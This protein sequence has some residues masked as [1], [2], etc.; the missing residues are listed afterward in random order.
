MDNTLHILAL[1]EL[2]SYTTHALSGFGSMIIAVTLGMHLYPIE[3]LLPVLVPLD[4]LLNMYIVIRHHK[5]VE[6]GLLIRRIL[7]LMGIGLSIGILLFNYLHS[8]MLKIIY[9]CFV[10]LL[11]VRE[12]HLL[13]KKIRVRGPLS[14]VEEASWLVAGGIIHGIFVSGGPLVV[15]VAGRIIPQK[16]NFRSTLAAL[17]IVLNLVLTASYI[18][19]GRL[20]LSSLS[21]SAML[22]P[23]VILCIVLG[24]RL[25]NLVDEYKFRIIVFILLFFAGTSLIIR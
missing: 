3:T 4:V 24:E 11:S 12:L 10:A 16:A 23:V 25:H 15:Y 9:G 21:S 22:L 5:Q 17:W 1:I 13:Y 19:T 8:G 2:L 20:N 6:R 14:N 18:V 7:P